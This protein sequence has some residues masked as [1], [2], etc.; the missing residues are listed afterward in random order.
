FPRTIVALARE[1]GH[2]RVVDDQVGSPTT[3]LELAPAV[4]DVLASGAAGVFHA[5]CEGAVSW[6]G[7]AAAVLADCG[8]SDVVLEPCASA[9]FPRP[10]RR[11]AYSVLDA[12]RLARLRG[13]TLAPW[14]RALAD[15][16]EVEP[17]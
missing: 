10:A 15:Y 3:T 17:L 8:L 1:R 4:W 12:S 2:L 16:L 14:R 13:R 5:A 6:H 9:E 7:L 11:P